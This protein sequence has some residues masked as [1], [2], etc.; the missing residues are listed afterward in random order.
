MRILTLCIL[1]SLGLFISCVNVFNNTLNNN[2][3]LFCVLNWYS[4]WN[5]IQFLIRLKDLS[6]FLF[7]WSK[8]LVTYKLCATVVN[9]FKYFAPF[10]EL[11]TRWRSRGPIIP[12]FPFTI[13]SYTQINCFNS[14]YSSSEV[15]RLYTLRKKCFL[16]RI[17][18]I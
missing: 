2:T 10:L 9:V 5:N 15:A 14:K 17:S 16:A 7:Y 12:L 18:W 13:V 6:R 11:P 8:K 3:S 4:I 1:F